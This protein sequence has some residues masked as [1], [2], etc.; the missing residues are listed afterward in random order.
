MQPVAAGRGSG[1]ARQTDDGRG[2]IG[3]KAFLRQ[4]VK[5]GLARAGLTLRTTRY[6]R[7]LETS[8]LDLIHE[9]HCLHRSL[10]FPDLADNPRREA[11]LAGLIG[12]GVSEALHVVGT[13]H[14]AFVHEGDI[15]E[16]GV[17]QGATSAL[18]ANEIKETE[19]TLWLFDSFE[20]LPPPSAEDELINDIYGL[21]TIGRYQGTMRYGEEQ[22][23]Q[24]LRAIDFPDTRFH[25]IK[26]WI[27]ETV[28]RPDL[29]SRVAF[30]Y[31]DFD[32]YWPTRTALDFLD[33]RLGAGGSIVV[34]DY[35][36]FS[37]GVRKAVDAFMAAKGPRYTFAPA[38]D[39]AGSFCI[40][41]RRAEAAGDQS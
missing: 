17:A 25:I 33:G 2:N 20:G 7:E 5:G 24:R 27:E 4:L 1:I 40:L 13:L 16:F 41:T 21:G 15:C 30:A 35:D 28:R 3:V 6:V 23:R 18:L 14:Q 22:V 36:Y 10:T 38:P 19:R 29:P 34:D 32:F 9:L 12:T 39:G 26:G 11:L 8:K 31:L 37:S